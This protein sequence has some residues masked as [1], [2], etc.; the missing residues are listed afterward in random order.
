MKFAQ[1]INHDY[2]SFGSDEYVYSYKLLQT[3]QSVQIKCYFDTYSDL[4]NII[5]V[6]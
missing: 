2:C 1:L 5:E 4:R 3:V 6:I